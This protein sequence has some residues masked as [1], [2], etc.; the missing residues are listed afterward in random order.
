M[1]DREHISQAD[2][3]ALFSKRAHDADWMRLQSRIMAHVNQCEQC[4]RFYEGAAELQSALEAMTAGRSRAGAAGDTAFRA[5]ASGE[6][7]QAPAKASG[8]ALSACVDCG[9]DGAFFID[10]SVEQEGCAAKY[11][12]NLEDDGARLEDDGGALTLTFEAGRLIVVA[13][14]RGMTATCR[15][16]AE[17]E[18]VDERT[19]P[20]DG[21]RQSLALPADALCVVEL[22]YA[23]D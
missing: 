3:L 15:V 16:T 14:E 7:W 9:E 4:R 19:F 11:G 5:A 10:D 12:M 8:G 6:R 2:W 13:M 18:T 21:S 22:E 20:A 23:R 1:Q 17:G